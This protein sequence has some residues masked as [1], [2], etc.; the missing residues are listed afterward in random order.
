MNNEV[1]FQTEKQV[2]FELFEELSKDT[3]IIKSSIQASL[4]NW[5]IKLPKNQNLIVKEKFSEMELDDYLL[6][7]IYE[8]GCEHPS[9][10]QAASIPTILKGDDLVVQSKSGTGKTLAY[11]TCLL[12]KC[13]SKGGLQAVILTPTR[14]LNQQISDVIAKLGAPNNI[15]VYTVKPDVKYMNQ[16]IIVGSPG[17]VLKLFNMDKEMAQT[18]KIIVIDEAD[19]VLNLDGMGSNAYV[20][21]KILEKAQ[22][23]YFS[24]TFYSHIKDAIADFSPKAICMYEKENLKPEK[25]KLYYLETERKEK[26]KALKSLYEYLSVGQSI[27]FVATKHMVE[28]LKKKLEADLHETACLHGDIEMAANE[29]IVEDFKTAKARVLISTDIFSRGMDI[30]QVN[31][32]INFDLPIVKGIP[33]LETY[34]HRIGRSGRFGR[35]GFVVDLVSDSNDLKAL[36]K[37]QTE[38]KSLS[39]KFSIKALEEVYEEN[40]SK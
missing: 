29:K 3:E 37:F 38:L 30:P 18:V 8:M 6:D 27:I 39:K 7:S 16:E 19:A 4:N 35:P 14:I 20:I 9:I 2:A 28:V 36:V 40:M 34:I 12:Q 10:I 1:N 31:L 22:K 26:M 32:V 13:V 21:L 17:G 11:G 25:I 33:N 23:I 5:E 15:N 24:A